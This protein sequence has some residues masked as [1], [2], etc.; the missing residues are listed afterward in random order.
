MLLSTVQDQQQYQFVNN[1]ATSSI[2]TAESVPAW[3]IKYKL[4]YSNKLSQN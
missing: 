1:D 2:V 3:Q 4:D